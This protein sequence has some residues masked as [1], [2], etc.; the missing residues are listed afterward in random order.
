MAAS[1]RV[2]VLWAVAAGSLLFH[3]LTGV[4]GRYLGQGHPETPSLPVTVPDLLLL[5][6]VVALPIL[7]FA[8]LAFWLRLRWLALPVLAG[9]W[10]GAADAIVF[11]YRSDFGATWASSEVFF[12]LTLDPVFTPLALALF[13]IPAAVLLQRRP[14]VPSR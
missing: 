8:A 4:P 10:L 1:L 11:P 6:V 9:L 13:L 2:L 3:A 7:A 12:E 5:A 14:T